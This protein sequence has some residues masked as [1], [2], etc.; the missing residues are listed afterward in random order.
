[1]LQFCSE[2]W[3]ESK[4]YLEKSIRMGGSA[5]ACFRLAM[6][7][8]RLGDGEN[9]RKCYDIAVQRMDADGQKNVDLNVLYEEVSKLLDL[10]GN[11]SE[12][13]LGYRKKP[14]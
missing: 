3:T 7:H 8:Q 10:S 1:M 4:K 9:A 6:V 12:H 5:S 2:N 13:A 14:R 11:Q